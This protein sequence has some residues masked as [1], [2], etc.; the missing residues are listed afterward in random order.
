MTAPGP[1]AERLN[2]ES[3][4]FLYDDG[5]SAS[6]EVTILKVQGFG[7]ARAYSAVAGHGASRMRQTGDESVRK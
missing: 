6:S 4:R 5:F 7:P 2:V 1:D 3:G